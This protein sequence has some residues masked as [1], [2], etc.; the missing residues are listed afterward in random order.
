M[1]NAV[2]LH[3]RNTPQQRHFD[4]CAAADRQQQAVAPLPLPAAPL[5]LVPAADSKSARAHANATRSLGQHTGGGKRSKPQQQSVGCA[6]GHR[7]RGVITSA[8]SSSTCSG[9]SD[10]SSMSEYFD[11]LRFRIS[12]NTTKA[13]PAQTDVRSSEIAATRLTL[14]AHENAWLVR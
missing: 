5:P 12:A 1:P 8:A 7:V 4:V 6:L 11:M 10:G 13:K 3:V 9:S 14:H 2:R